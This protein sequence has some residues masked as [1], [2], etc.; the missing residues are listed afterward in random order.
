[1]SRWGCL[2]PPTWGV[3]GGR[4]VAAEG[5]AVGEL[6]DVAVGINYLADVADDGTLV[7]RFEG[8]DAAFTSAPGEQV[9]LVV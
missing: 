7:R 5:L 8:K 6:A 1:M 4:G 9:D 3:L 2:V